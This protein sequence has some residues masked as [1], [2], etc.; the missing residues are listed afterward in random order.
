YASG[1]RLKLIEMIRQTEAVSPRSIDARIPRDLE[2]IVMKAI[3]KDP[4]RRYQSADELGEDL[5]RFLDDEPIQARRTTTSERVWRWCRR[6]PVEAALMTTVQLALVSLVLVAIWSNAKI[7]RALGETEAARGEAVT[8]R[9]AA[10]AK[11][12]DA[13][14]S[15][16]RALRLTHEPGWRSKALENLRSLALLETPRR[17]L[18]ELRGEAIACIGEVEPEGGVPLPGPSLP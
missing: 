15:E 3:D 10:V 14:L 1:D 6:H 9:D 7:R 17:D 8:A 16:T 13:L 11:T 18:T 4:R 2:T 5:Q 12:Y